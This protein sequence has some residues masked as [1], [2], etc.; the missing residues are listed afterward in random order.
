MS[1]PAFQSD[2]FGG[3]GAGL[4]RANSYASFIDRYTAAKA[5]GLSEDEALARANQR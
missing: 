2:N 4:R 1:K 5:E 3:R